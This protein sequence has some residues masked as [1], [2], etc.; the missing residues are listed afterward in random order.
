MLIWCLI[1]LLTK[2]VIHPGPLAAMFLVQ[3]AVLFLW[4]VGCTRFYLWLYPPRRVV[5]VYG[6]RPA[7]GLMK[8]ISTRA[9]RFVIGETVHISEGMERVRR[10]RHT[11]GS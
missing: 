4:G 1:I 8:K 10:T 6:G 2:R 3:T 11:I 5:L 9:D 7:A